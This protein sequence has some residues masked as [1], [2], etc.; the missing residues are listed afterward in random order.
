M[1]VAAFLSLALGLGGCA[2]P[3]ARHRSAVDQAYLQGAADAVKELYWARQALEAPRRAEP[4]GRTEYFTWEEQGAAG[5]GRRL[6]PET[7]AVPVFVPDPAPA[8]RDP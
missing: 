3:A 5:D 6:A 1:R 2:S 7:V 4:A 8:A